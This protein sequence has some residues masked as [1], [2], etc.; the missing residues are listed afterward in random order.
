[1]KEL[2]IRQPWASLIL[3]GMKDVE[4][5]SWRTSFRGRLFIHA[6]VTMTAADY[7]DALHFMTLRFGRGQALLMLPA[8][9]NLPRGGIIGSVT[10]SDIVSASDSKWFT[11]PFGWVM[12]DP[13]QCEFHS[14]RGRLGIFHPDS[15]PDSIL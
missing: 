6:A 2:S 3:R 4:N 9:H 12:R 1:M 13:R 5:R 15:Q 11:G 7:F 8:K 10:V 14:T